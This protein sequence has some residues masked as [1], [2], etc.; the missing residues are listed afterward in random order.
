MPKLIAIFII[1]LLSCS[2][3]NSRIDRDIETDTT[4]AERE[5]LKSLLTSIIDT[6]SF[7]EQY[8][9]QK[10][11]FNQLEIVFIKNSFINDTLKFV[12]SFITV[13]LVD[14][15][16]AINN[17]IQAYLEFSEFRFESDTLKLFLSY[18]N[19]G[20]EFDFEMT[21]KDCRWY[22]HDSGFEY[23]KSNEL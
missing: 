18:H 13:I 11:D 6:H 3:S 14:K 1:L 2:N 22:V 17:K 10:R 9:N 19:M 12:D 5:V 8:E 23:I 7:R 4:C 21:Q 15:Q 20:G 16:I